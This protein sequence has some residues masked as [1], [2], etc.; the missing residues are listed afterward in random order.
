MGASEAEKQKRFTKIYGGTLSEWNEFRAVNSLVPVAERLKTCRQG[1]A[2]EEF[3]Q[4]SC[5]VFKYTL[6]EGGKTSTYVLNQRDL[7]CKHRQ[8]GSS[9]EQSEIEVCWSHVTRGAEQYWGNTGPSSSC[10]GS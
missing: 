7:C 5:Q 3:S 6:A 4:E 9:W 2:G 8:M 1:L 10:Q